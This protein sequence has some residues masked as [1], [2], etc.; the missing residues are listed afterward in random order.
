MKLFSSFDQRIDIAKYPY[1]QLVVCEWSKN[2]LPSH[3]PHRVA[4][5]PVTINAYEWHL[6]R[7]SRISKSGFC[8]RS[9]KT[10]HRRGG[11]FNQLS[12]S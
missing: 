6:P 8:Y 10:S 1:N 3:P 5:K 2:K 9:K 11:S 4:T 7:L 12:G